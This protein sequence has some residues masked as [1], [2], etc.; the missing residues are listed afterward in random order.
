MALIKIGIDHI[1]LYYELGKHH[2]QNK[3]TTQRTIG[4]DRAEQ[5]GIY[6]ECG[7]SKGCFAAP[8]GCIGRKNCLFIAT[9]QPLCEM[10]RK[11]CEVT[12]G[13]CR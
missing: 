1:L 13:V 6:S 5:V 12:D 11:R 10:T 7:K 4:A 3:L 8:I 2:D 9:W